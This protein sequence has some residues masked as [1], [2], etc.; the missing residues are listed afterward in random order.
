MEPQRGPWAELLV[1]FLFPAS[2]FYNGIVWKDVLAAHLAA[3]AFLLVIPGGRSPPHAGLERQQ[4]G[5]TQP[6]A[7]GERSVETTSR[8]HCNISLVA[9]G[10]IVGLAFN[11][12]APRLRVFDNRRQAQ[13]QLANFAPTSA[14]V[15]SRDEFY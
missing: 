9:A 3:L 6:D 13:R 14:I 2:F 11:S 10:S 12:S 5:N 15:A 7:E 8:I 1:W 4:Q